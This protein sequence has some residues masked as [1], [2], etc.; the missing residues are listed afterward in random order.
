MVVLPNHRGAAGEETPM[1]D[2]ISLL[3]YLAHGRQG[4]STQ[5]STATKE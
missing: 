4:V 5:H 3:V 2:R 1:S